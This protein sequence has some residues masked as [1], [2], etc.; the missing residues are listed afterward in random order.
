MYD[1]GRVLNSWQE[2]QIFSSSVPSN[3]LWNPTNS[4]SMD[5]TDK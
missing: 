2:Q 3:R 4:Y 5:I 1:Q